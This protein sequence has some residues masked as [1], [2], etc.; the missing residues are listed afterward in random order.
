MTASAQA[1]KMAENR[2]LEILVKITCTAEGRPVG[3]PEVIGPHD[4]IEELQRWD[5]DKVTTFGV[6]GAT[7]VD[8]ITFSEEQCREVYKK[9]SDGPMHTPEQLNLNYHTR[10]IKYQRCEGQEKII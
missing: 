9:V 5:R 3:E 8:T 7:G 1:I 4:R 10:V 6:M 2:P